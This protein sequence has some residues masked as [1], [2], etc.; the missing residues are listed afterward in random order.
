MRYTHRQRLQV[1]L[2][3][4]AKAILLPKALLMTN[5]LTLSVQASEKTAS[6]AEDELAEAVALLLAIRP[7]IPFEAV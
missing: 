5:A 4:A 3:R 7:A 6:A 2:Q 1:W